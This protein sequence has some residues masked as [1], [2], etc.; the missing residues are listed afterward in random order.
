MANRGAAE[1]GEPDL[2]LD[3]FS[4]GASAPLPVCE[5]YWS[6]QDSAWKKHWGPHQGLMWIHCPRVD[7]PRVVAKICK[8]RSKAVFV[9]PMGCTEE[10]STR[11]WVAS[12]DNMTLN[13]LVLPGRES[14]YQDAKGQ[15]MPPQSWPTAFHYVD[16][17]LEQ[18]DATDF[19]W[20]NRVIA[21][22][23]QQCFAVSPVDMGD[24][25]DLLSDEE[26]D[27]VQGYMDRPFH[28]SVAQR[29]GKGQY[30]AW[31]E[32]DAIVSGS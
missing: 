11:D 23:W 4:S 25:E 26:L 16:G 21:E 22:P 31:W 3:A 19:L 5:K 9:V 1:L 17:G 30:K 20:V 28:D 12:L 13:N 2:A 27:L 24:S 32:V 8:D 7:I 14:V 15:P 10:E 18:A 6:A 29:D